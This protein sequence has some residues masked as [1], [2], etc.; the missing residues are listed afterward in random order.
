MNSSHEDLPT[1]FTPTASDPAVT[2][3]DLIMSGELDKRVSRAGS[4][5]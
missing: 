3:D 1:L 2:V 5:G 4:G